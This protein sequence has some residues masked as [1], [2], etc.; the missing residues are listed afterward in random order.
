MQQAYET[1][2]VFRL[3]STT[4]FKRSGLESV[5]TFPRCF[6]K[7]V[8]CVTLKRYV[9]NEAQILQVK[10]LEIILALYKIV[11]SRLASRHSASFS[12][13]YYNHVAHVHARATYKLIYK[14]LHKERSFVISRYDETMPIAPRV[15]NLRIRF[16]SQPIGRPLSDRWEKG[17]PRENSFVFLSIGAFVR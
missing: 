10:A 9:M 16:S 17:V 12:P 13:F 3:S 11:P 14:Y 15:F 1:H 2:T 7:C 5:L 4:K 8:K 6:P